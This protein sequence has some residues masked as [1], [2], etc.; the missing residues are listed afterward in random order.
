MRAISI[1]C[2]GVLT[3]AGLACPVSAETVQS[4]QI[5][6]RI[7]AGCVVAADAGG[8][9]GAVD[10]GS[11]AGVAG[12]TASAT[13]L[14]T[15]GAG[16]SIECTPGLSAALTAD[17]GD[18]PAGGARY[19]QRASGAGTIRY[20]LFA[21]NAATPWTNGTVPLAF[22]GAA[23]LVPIRAVA[24]LAAP[25]AAGVYSDTVRVTLTW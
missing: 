19:L 10:L 25:A 13:L 6:A 18:H 9:W 11:V 15:A 14:S 5:S 8:R 16:I 7:V 1:A 12:T 22:S 2:C 23:R 4:F 17:G 3:V 21:D 24:T 20:Q